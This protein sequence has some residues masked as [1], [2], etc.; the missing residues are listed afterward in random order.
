[1]KFKLLFLT[2]LFSVLS[3]GQ[4][5]LPVSRT[6]WATTPTGWTETNTANYNTA[7]ACSGNDG[8]KFA[9]SFENKVVFFTG[10]PS[11]LSFVVKSNAA[12]TSSL[13]VEESIDGS[14]YTTVINLSGTVDLPTT[15]TTKGPYT[16]NATSRYVRW[17]FTKGSSNLTMDDVSITAGAVTPTITL[18]P[19]TLT[20]FTYFVGSGPS[21]NQTFTA[22]GTSLTANI[23]LTAPTD[24]EIATAA[25]GP[26]SGTITLTQAAGTV[27]ATTIYARL[28][29]G[30]AVGAYNLENIA[31]TSAGATT[32]NVSC[33]GTVTGSLASDVVA[34]AASESA[35]VNSTINNNTPLTSATGVKVWDISVRDGGATL[36]DTDN[37]PTIVNGLTFAQAVGNSVGTWSDAINTIELFDGAT[38]L[39][40]ATVT[41]NQIQFTGLN[42]SVADNTAKTLSVRMS[43]KCPLGPGAVD[44]DDFGFSLSNA[45]T[46]FSAAGSGKL[47]F[48]AAT[49]ANGSNVIN[50]VG[51]K[52]VVTTQPTTTAINANMATVVIKATDACGNTDRDFTGNVAVTSTGTMTSSPVIIAAV[53]GAATF[54][55]IVHT[56]LGTGLTLNAT[57]AGLTPVAS[58]TFNITAVTT[59]S[60]GDFAVIAMNSNISCYPA[61][62]N[63][64]YSAGDDEVSFMTFKDI[65]NGDTFYMTDNGFERGGTGTNT[66]GNSEGTYQFTRTGGTIIAGTVITFRL[67]NVAPF[68]E[69][70]SPDLNW[71]F[72]KATGFTGTLNLNSGGDQFFFMQGGSWNNPTP[73]N[74]TN[75]DATY[76]PGTLLYA[77]NMNTVWNAGVNNTQNSGLPLALRCF[78]LT[79]G[80]ASDF[81]EYTGPVTPV[82]K[83]DWIA[84]LNNPS[85]WTSRTCA[86]FLRTHVGQV[87]GVTTGTFVN[88][89]WTGAKS[90]DWFDCGNWQTLEV[91]TPSVN[92]NVNATYALR[93][94]VI[95]ITSSNATYYNN[96]AQSN[97]IS[98]TGRKVQIEGNA[99]NRLDAYG[100]LLLDTTG[101]LDMD[102]STVAADGR[103]NLY[104]NW[105][106]N[107]G[108]VAFS[109]GNGTVHFTGSTPQIIS[110]VTPEGTETFYNVIL[111]NNFTTSVS[112]N[113]IATGDLTVNATKT[114][115][116]SPNNYVQV[117]NNVTNNGTFNVQNNGSLVQ[118]N[119]AGVNT[120]NI[121]LD[122]VSNV[123]LQDY[124]Y[125]SSPVVGKTVAGMFPTT[126]YTYSWATTTT[127]ANGGQGTWVP[128]SGNMVAGNGYIARAPSGTSASVVTPLTSSF[129]GVP[130]NGIFT[131]TISRGT[132]YTTVGTQGIMRTVTDDNWNLLGNPYPSAL[133]VVS[134]GGFLDTNPQLA[135]F[136]KIWTHAQLPTNPVDPFYQNFVTNYYAADYST[137]NRTGLTSGPGDYKIGSGQGFMVLMNAGAAGSSTVT[138]NN[139]MRSRTFANNQFYKSANAQTNSPIERHRI[140][141]DLIS[142]TETTRTLIGYVA[143]ATQ[144]L[145]NMFDAFTDYK[146]AQ[147]F[148]SVINDNPYVIQGRTLP[149]DVNDR[150][151]LGIKTPTNGTYTIAIA[152]VDGLFAAGN[153]KIYIEDK[154]LNTINDITVTPYQF[155]ATQ[156][157][158]NDRFVLRYTDQTLNNAGFD[159]V[160]NGVSIFGSDNEIKINSNLQNIQDYTVYN[161]L[162]QILAEKNNVNTNQSAVNSILKN[163]QTLVVK[164][165]LANGQT[166]IKKIMF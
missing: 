112:N 72:A 130:Q 135:G 69:F 98:I 159:L 30:L 44:G 21:A 31:G 15:C 59:F 156:G 49:S 106:N 54:N 68:V 122:R 64:T 52:L 40:V 101:A 152:T 38:N 114:L 163:N 83:L 14:T 1:M 105:T 166:V 126:S 161:V 2:L 73:G 165:T 164:V 144:G 137:Y 94:A 153:Q 78:S 8:A 46:T 79:P 145:D 102:D 50:V 58:T 41:A 108:N 143:D 47:A 81:V 67:R 141:L 74:T 35:L 116:V 131:P 142:P 149:F 148:Y 12:T 111:N 24:Y 36:N 3:W 4:T 57:S 88:G 10:T 154:L 120:G 115:T 99:N 43:L 157:I 26:F 32:T 90:T 65:Q 23:L 147:N 91:P 77:F 162:G 19:A 127:N 66:W 37:L 22:S 110:N 93:D 27:A 109:E 125:W 9:N 61:G 62:P 45:N 20:G 113:I 5:T 70:T 60:P 51:T 25:V 139:S 100:N 150:V 107:T 75:N 136:V 11:Q 80:G 92:V 42:I 48:A 129:T 95:D 53:S 133:D 82:P 134:T 28:K 128:Y 13:L 76:T 146:P 6:A 34:V 96:I 33:S 63:G 123:R 160:E 29:T 118:I 155:T 151:P 158:T 104:G 16:L 124:V 89:V 17:T 18:T 119:N 117:T 140:W 121:N 71:S 39:G 85:N 84:R 87:Y 86:T 56:V 55:T 7:F 132:D 97:D 138:F 103:I